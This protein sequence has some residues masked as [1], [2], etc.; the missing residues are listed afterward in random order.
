ME[1]NKSVA[2]RSIHNPTD[3]GSTANETSFGGS[4]D[5]SGM[6]PPVPTHIYHAPE[7][8]KKEDSFIRRAKVL[9][10]VALLA[11]VVAVAVSTYLLVSNQ[12]KEGFEHQFAGHASEISALVRQR[13]E[14]LFE[15]LDSAS[16]M[17][18]S[19]ASTQN[20]SWPF[21]TVD[22]WSSKAERLFE[23]GDI[24]QS[25][26]ALAPIVQQEMVNNW[27]GYVEQLA[28]A[29]YQSSINHEEFNKTLEDL[30]IH[31]IPYVHTY[32]AD[33]SITTPVEREG[34]VVPIWQ[35]Y[36]LK[37]GEIS[38]S[39][40]ELPTNYDILAGLDGDTHLIEATTVSLK[41]VIAFPTITLDETTGK[42]RAR[43]EIVQPIF[44]KVD[45]REE[46]GNVVAVLWWQIDW[47]TVL[48]GILDADI[49]GILAVLH[50]SCQTSDLQDHTNAL[51]YRINGQ[52]SILLASRDIHSPEF[53]AMEVSEVVIDFGVGQSN[54][55][56]E[57]C[58][59]TVTLH[60]YPTNDFRDHFLTQNALYYVGIVVLIFSFTSSVFLLYDHFVKVR[61]K[62][63]MDRITRQDMIVSD[64]FPSAIRDRLYNQQFQSGQDSQQD[65]LLDPLDFGQS[66]IVGSAPLADLFPNTTV[67]FADIVGFTAWSSQREPSQVFILLESIY[68][69]F[70][71][72][73]YRHN[74]F[75]VET[76]GDCYVAVAGLPDPNEEHAIA[77]CRFARSCLKKMKEMTLK[78]EVSLG[79]DT[80]DLAIRIGIN[81][82]QVTAGVLRGERSRFQLFGD[83]MNTA[84]R[85]EHSGERNRIQLSQATADLLKESGLERWIY[86]RSS[87]IFVKGKGDMQT[88]FIKDTRP[89]RSRIKS[90]VSGD[91]STVSETLETAAESDEH[92]QDSSDESESND[93]IDYDLGEIE[94]MSKLDRLVEWNVEILTPLLQQIIASRAGVVQPIGHL[95]GLETTVGEEG[96][97]LEEFVPIISLKR[98]EE[99]EL[100]SRMEPSEVVIHEAARSQLRSLLSNLALLYQDNPFHNF[101]HASH[102]TA[103]VKKLLSRIVKVGEGNGLA[104]SSQNVNLVD[105]AGHSYGITS[106]PFTQFAVIFSA[107]IHDADHPGVSNAQLVKEKTR[108]AQ[109][110][111]NKSVAEQNSVDL[112]WQML[113]GDEY[114]DLRA[115]IYQTEEDLR[116]FRQLV[117]NTVLATD[118]CDKE[119]QT[120]RKNRW[121]TAFSETPVDETELMQVDRKATIV[122]EHLIQASDVSHT[123]QHW[124]IYKS[125]NKK[126]FMECYGAYRTGRAET[127]PSEGWYKGEIGFFDFYIIPLAR[128]LDN[129]GVFGV[130]SDEY[131]NYA[132]ANRDEWAREGKNIVK[133]FLAEYEGSVQELPLAGEALDQSHR[134][135]GS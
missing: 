21:V 99:D 85:M 53:D 41:P 62:V 52:R 69:A 13:I 10:A 83:T 44:E 73:A 14:T 38:Q 130:S 97:V 112:A 30:V 108:N 92:L 15:S 51:T 120:L 74:V 9:V 134:F 43:S 28:P 124:H 11:A 46:D 27:T 100:R 88:Y 20:E 122:I 90:T 127:D 57:G 36:P 59:P 39:V 84:A 103:S 6:T 4:S 106:D 64:V 47:G 110:Y 94:G 12:E 8:A 60:L 23:L 105:L 111:K 25:M 123:M 91:I 26:L 32:T 86:P 42:R 67:I 58:I 18:S 76:V 107:V 33:G 37:I 95:R 54:Y 40:E 1:D 126:F 89:K 34:H 31:T 29:W 79:P 101:E 49:T 87:T 7:V 129:C 116:R 128:K 55:P 70:D 82:G 104:Q 35:S 118:I 22:H 135:Y 81:S 2:S 48:S 98:F 56:M 19:E 117:V 80:A 114:S 77:A 113:M 45:I 102:V 61:Q 115:C 50:S 17:I 72:I 96:T 16:V 66:N 75:K 121:E 5:D 132:K 71:K 133:E 68:S 78:L 65:D 24:G 93:E 125:W 63:V 3:I 119:L 131:M 109:I